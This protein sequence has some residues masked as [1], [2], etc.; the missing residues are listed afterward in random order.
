[1][2]EPTQPIR[3]YRYPLSGHAHR[4]ELFLS[5]LGL[6]FVNCEIDLAKGEHKTPE[7][8]RKNPFGQVP[9]IED[10]ELT[11]A[12]SNAILVYLAM[13]YDPTERWLPRAAP[14]A[15]QVQRWLSVAAGELLFG[16]ASARMIKVFGTKLDL[17]RARAF[18]AQLLSVLEAQLAERAFLVGAEP[19]IADVALFT[20]TAHAP[21]GGI[22]LAPYPALQAWL[23]RIEALPGFVPM[24][25]AA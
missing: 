8:L 7:F 3:L 12:D 5:L 11:L 19:T 16:P 2:N 10:G 24:R 18:A 9:V 22:S 17:E 1:M 14:R 25:R 23:G 6:N 20:Y 21:E 4:V 15:A 13:R